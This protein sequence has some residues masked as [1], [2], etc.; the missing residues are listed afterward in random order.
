MHVLRKVRTVHVMQN[1]TQ[2]GVYIYTYIQPG[3]TYTVQV[4]PYDTQSL[5]LASNVTVFKTE[6]IIRY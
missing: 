2:Y 5:L 3:E 1:K 4:I 6:G